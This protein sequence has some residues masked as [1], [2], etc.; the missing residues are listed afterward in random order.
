M[1]WYKTMMTEINTQISQQKDK[2]TERTK[3]VQDHIEKRSK[4]LIEQFDK[5][6]NVLIE[7]LSARE[8]TGKKYGRPK[9]IAQ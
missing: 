5:D 7:D 6:Y 1:E 4:E 3:E 2:R 9:R 8:G